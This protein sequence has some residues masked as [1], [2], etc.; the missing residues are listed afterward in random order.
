MQRVLAD[1]R[2]QIYGCGRQD[3]QAGAIDRR[4]LAT[5][6]FLVASGFNPTVTSLNCGHSY[7]TASGNVSE[8]SHR[9]R[10]RHRRGQRHPDPRQPG[11]GLDHRPRHPAPAH[12]AGHDEAAPDHLADEVRRTPTTRSR[13]PTTT[14]TSTSASS[15]QYG[16]NSKLPSSSTPCSSPSQ[17]DRLIERLG[18]IDNPKVSVEPS[19]AALKAKPL[20]QGPLR[21]TTARFRFVQWEFAG[22]LGPPPGRYVVRRY[23]GDD[24]REVVVVTEADAPRRLARREPPAGTVPVTRV[25]VIDAVLRP[26]ADA[27]GLARADADACAGALPRRPPRRRRRPG[28][29]DPA[30]RRGRAPA[31]GTGAELAEGDWTEARELPAPEPPRRRRRSKH[32]PAERLAALLSARDV[33]LACEELTLRARGDLDRG[34]HR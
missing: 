3:I 14:I 10:R 15:P 17:W 23:A 22:R 28:A 19:K 32:R 24:V 34:R 13:W 16:T 21:R 33:V 7:L 5:L 30:R 1:P 25:T 29:P 12:P 26:D 27:G 2:I 11:Q 9:H 18:E 20:A 4:V 8:H 6:E 31:S